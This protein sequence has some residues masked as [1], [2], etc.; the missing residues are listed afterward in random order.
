MATHDYVIANG[1]GAA[2]RSDLNNALAAIVSNNS[3]T[4]EPATTYAYQWWADTT[5]NLLKIRN[6]A[7]NAWITLRELDGTLLMEEG[8]VSAP[9]LA[10]AVDLDTGL[11]RSAANKLNIATAGAER[12][13]IG[14]SEVVFNDPS[15]DVDFRVESNGNTHML[16]V[17]GGTDRVGIGESDP[18]QTL[19]ISE[20]ASGTTMGVLIHNTATAD[21]SDARLTF[22]TN[23]GG[24]EKTRGYIQATGN[25]S[26]VGNLIFATRKSGTTS[27]SAR[28]DSSGR[29]LMGSSVAASA[30]DAQYAYLQIAG[31]TAGT[32]GSVL[33]L[34]R[35]EAAASMSD[36]DSLG[37]IIFTGTT[38]GDFASIRGSVDGSPSGSD[39]PGRI[40]FSTTADGASSPTERLRIDSSGRVGFG[41]EFDLAASNRVSINPTD[42]LIGLGMDGRESY[43]TST[44]GC[45][46]YSGSGATGTTKAG[47]LILQSRS[48]V[49]R[50]ITFVTGSTP[51]K[52]L[53][54]Y[55]SGAVQVHGSFSK[56]SGSFKIDHPLP[57]K[58]ATHN[59]V[60]S[61][62]EGPQ[63]DL[64]YRG[65]VDLTAGAATVNLDTAARMT[66]GTFVLLNTNVQCFT[67]NESD[68]TA[69]RGSVSGNTLTIV[70]EDNT[71]TATVSWLVIGER[72]DQHMLDTDWTDDNGR[73][74]TEPEKP[75]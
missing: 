11:F 49:N 66:E 73:V 56:G 41:G 62:I 67:S 55:G 39:F 60:H 46:I 5:N 51:T 58:T 40:V 43:I 8:S 6:S 13:E 64:I 52:R 74:I 38:G 30:G 53:S 24:A 22:N 17:E 25:T 20:A 45:Y 7:N 65:K 36:G 10:F 63:A 61:F 75:S 2:V 28:I 42:G 37:T 27:E 54:V 59:L 18:D 12:L 26:G 16:F 47:E 57:A 71:S 4:S 72:Q 48:N 3:G 70:A 21:D 14:S 23:S 15:N 68:W 32:S 33:A 9:S 29:L 35:G 44:S 1:T 19:H 34:K 50:D 69:V 31:N